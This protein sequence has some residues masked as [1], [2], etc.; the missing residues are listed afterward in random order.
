MLAGF[1][2]IEAESIEEAV[3]IAE[4]AMYGFSPASA[5][6]ASRSPP[7]STATMPIPPPPI[8]T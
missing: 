1:N 2:L 7:G 8:A 3:H 6:K 5:S 4:G